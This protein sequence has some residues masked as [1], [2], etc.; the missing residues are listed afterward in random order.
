MSL[1]KDQN[2]QAI[3]ILGVNYWP[4]SS[5]LNMWTEWHPEELIEDIRR[6]K[7]LGLNCCR[8]FLFLPA[9][10]PTAERVEPLQLE[11]LGFFL[12][13]CEKH[14]LY[15][16]PTFIVGHMSGEDW[17][18]A[19]R[20][21]ANFI[22]DERVIEITRR[23]ITTVVQAVKD[24]RYIAGWVLTNELPNFVGRQSAADI[25]AWVRQMVV[26][27]KALD[28]HRPVCVGDG[29]WAPEVI[30]EQTGFELRKL[31]GYQDFVG[32]HYY[33]R[34]L[35]AWRHTFT[36]AFRIRMAREWGRPV[37]VEEFGTSTTLCSEENQAKYFR[38]VFYSA[39]CNG[40]EG[41]L[42]WCLNDFD[43]E[44]KRPY[45]HH[46][47]E[48]R[49][50]IVRTD[51]SLKPAAREFER[52]R[53]VVVNL[54]QN[55]YQKVERPV[56]LFIPSNYYYQYPY[57]FQPEFR[58]WYDFYLQVYALMKRANLEVRMIVEPAQEL[59]AEGRY[60]H[61]WQLSPRDVPLLFMPRLKIMTKQTW[62]A[63]RQYVESGGCLYFSFANDSWIPDWQRLAGI[64][65]DC[66]FGVPDFRPVDDIE[67]RALID[68]GVWR[69]G[70]TWRMPLIGTEPEASYCPILSTA[71]K[72]LMADQ[73]GMPFL[74]EN[75]VGQGRVVF[76]S[77]PVEIL[78]LLTNSQQ[79]ESQLVRIYR[80][81]GI[82]YRQPGVIEVQGDGLECG[83]WY[84]SG[85]YR[86]I[87]FNHSWDETEGVINLAN[88]NLIV[89]STEV[90]LD[91]VD[92]RR[93]R[94]KLP[95]KGACQLDIN[96]DVVR[97][98]VNTRRT[99]EEVQHG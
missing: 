19:W 8:F 47:F 75:R 93:Y 37:I 86:L 46:L 99:H 55:N 26:S 25:A 50:G 69:A 58:R 91:K 71:G 97:S 72:V 18:V 56:G 4:A 68:F 45:T 61:V 24:Y 34:E 16:L 38:S 43:F 92:R 88:E 3:F 62:R 90:H 54:L 73:Y 60:T 1:F 84:K 31:N 80:S 32:L 66:K 59:E 82:E 12:Q 9:F 49:F 83:L 44:E 11:R 65:M 87:I 15:T 77:Y 98:Q 94:F 95:G 10:M 76:S 42:S 13:E 36:T 14:Q 29:A 74:I 48:E 40:A 30:G 33:P 27:I 64:E 89:I 81:L 28:P 20:G 22:I 35:S 7:G 2:G 5:G 51:R 17:D 41:A 63:L 21:D 52:F 57:Q 67:V 70:E 53:Q 79:V 6:M 78:S 96:D 39:L 23:Y 85:S